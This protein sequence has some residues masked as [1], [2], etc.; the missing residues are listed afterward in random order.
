MSGDRRQWPA[1]APDGDTELLVLARRCL[2]GDEAAWRTLYRGQAPRI[3]RF[4]CS[5]LGPTSDL[6]DLDD[7]VQQV[8]V[9]TLGR[10]ASFRGEAGLTTWMYGIAAN[11]AARHRRFQFRWRRRGHA[12]S[13]QL[14]GQEGGDPADGAQARAAWRTVAGA[15]EAMDFRLRVAW[16][17]RE[18]EG[19]AYDE[20][21]RAL[22]VPIGTVRSRLS[23]ARQ[24]RLAAIEAAEVVL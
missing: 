23:T 2:E 24:R 22:D 1:V 6:D 3:T 13:E 21:A 15:L 20:I 9:E 19:M 7:L 17:M 8:F 18:V 10:L 14:D 4:L 16:T 5:L 11:V 12:W